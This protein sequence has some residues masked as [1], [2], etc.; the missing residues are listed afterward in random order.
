V[1]VVESLNHALGTLMESDSNVYMLGEDI[2]DP[3]GGAFKVTAGLTARF[4][5]RVLGTPISEA[6]IVGMATGMAMHGLRPIAEIMFG[7]FLL[8]AAD[9]IINH[10][11]K[12]SWVYD[13]Q[14]SVPLVIRTPMGGRRGYGPTHSQSLEKHFCGVPGLSVYAVSQYADPGGVLMRAY[15]SETPALVIE[16][17]A[18]YSRRVTTLPAC[19][20]ADVAVVTYG[21]CV[22]HAVEAAE[23]LCDEDGLA[24]RVVALTQLSPFPTTQ[25]IHETADVSR[26][27]AVEEGSE[28]WGFGSECARVLMEVGQRVTFRSI[29]APPHPIPA[30]PRWERSI[31]PDASAIVTAIRG[32][33]TL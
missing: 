3:Y 28:G 21:G 29:A 15:D 25:L 5:G 22:E 30:C 23:R 24:V 6:A 8:L 32:M 27:L 14:V 11:A 12:F 19:E 33:M 1:R 13:D 7:D 4:P 16:N 17:K 31:L 2:A 10:A 26:V 9:Q 20:D 18:L